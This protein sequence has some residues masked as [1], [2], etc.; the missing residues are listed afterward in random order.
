MALEPELKSTL[1]GLTE[2]EAR[3]FNRIFVM[4]FLGFVVVAIIAH[5]L[6]WIWRPWGVAAP[7]TSTGWLLDGAGAHVHLA[8]HAAGSAA[9]ALVA[10][11]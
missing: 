6:A 5:I 10:L 11:V 4:S 1:S 8:L 3:E 2:G 7:S 9:H